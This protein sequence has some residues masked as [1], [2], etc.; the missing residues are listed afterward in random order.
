[1]VYRRRDCGRQ[2][3]V[4]KS[5]ILAGSRLPEIKCLPAIL[6]LTSVRTGIPDTQMA[7]DLGTTQ[8]SAWLLASRAL[9]T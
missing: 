6:M 9:Q 8:K 7:R 2:V 3:S 5:P 1:M 4:R